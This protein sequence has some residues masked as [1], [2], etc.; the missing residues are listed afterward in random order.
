LDEDYLGEHV[1]DALA[2]VDQIYQESSPDFDL[3]RRLQSGGRSTLATSELAGDP[4]Q[5]SS[6]TGKTDNPGWKL[7]KWKFLPMVN[8]TLHERPSMKW[9][10]FIEADTFLLWSQLLQYLSVLDS[11]QPIY[12]GSQ[13]FAHGDIFAH[14]GSG[15]I[16]SL[17][18]LQKIVPYYSAN[19]ATIEE[20]TDGHW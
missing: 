15:F 16:V 4:D 13:L 8:R 7:D 12:A 19:K 18:A 11:T 17:P 20:F 1:S 9:Y 6:M 14:G 5:F 2:D 3:W 10:V